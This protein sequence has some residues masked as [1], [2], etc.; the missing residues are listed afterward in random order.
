[1]QLAHADARRDAYEDRTQRPLTWLALAFLAVYAFPIL[2]PGADSQVLTTCAVVSWII[3]GIFG[4]DYLWRL[5][6][7]ED[8]R[9]FLRRHVLELLTVLLPMLR[10]LRALRVLSL[11]NLAAR[12]DDDD[13]LFVNV[14]QAIAGAVAL[15]VT[16]GSVAILD[17]ERGAKDAN[18]GTFGDA[19]WWSITT[20]TTVGYGDRFPVT[21]AGR[22]IAAVMMLL[23]IALIGIVT[24]SIASWAV[25]FLA[26]VQREAD[27]D[28]N[29]V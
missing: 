26:R 22:S 1:M 24:A 12:L 4:A 28:D 13:G 21:F 27:I 10:P 2:D 16:I 6:L 23:G 29:E 3:W 8:R 7:A 17:A 5:I 14:A 19:L 11:A 20:I 15:L 18:I 25:T 9:Q